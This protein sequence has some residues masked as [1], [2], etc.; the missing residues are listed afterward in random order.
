M[1]SVISSLANRVELKLPDNIQ[2]YKR[3]HIY[4][5]GMNAFHLAAKYHP[6]AVQIMHQIVKNGIWELIVKKNIPETNIT[7]LQMS[8]RSVNYR[9]ESA[10]IG[11][12][13]NTQHMHQNDLDE[14]DNFVGSWPK[15]C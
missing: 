5:H 3:E 15:F 12:N 6:E 9:E 2:Y 8:D 14:S 10:S 1:K 7:L 4:L 11:E 13:Q